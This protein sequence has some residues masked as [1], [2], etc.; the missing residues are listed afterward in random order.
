MFNKSQLS[1]IV[2][3]CVALFGCSSFNTYQYPAPLVMVTTTA[4]TANGQTTQITTAIPEECIYRMPDLISLP[5]TPIDELEK[6]GKDD[7]EGL[8]QIQ[9]DYIR[10]LQQFIRIRQ[11]VHRDAYQA[12][13]KRCRT[14]SPSTPVEVKGKNTG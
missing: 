14:V 2:V 8:D 5:R 4:G 6:I 10:Q 1:T 7:D 11:K 3:L 9:Q 13:L 12:Y